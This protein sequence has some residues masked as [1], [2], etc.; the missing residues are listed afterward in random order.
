MLA[1]HLGLKPISHVYDGAVKVCD[2]VRGEKALVSGMIRKVS[3]RVVQPE[4]QTALLLYG[5]V[6]A[7]RIDELEKRLR[8]EIGFRNVL[9]SPIGP[10]VI[11]NT[12]PQALAVA[13]Y[14][15]ARG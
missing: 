14:G 4:K 12:G 11:T 13:F 6:P 15:Q 5:D 3:G 8:T 1:K 9:R 10:S 7:A 2:K